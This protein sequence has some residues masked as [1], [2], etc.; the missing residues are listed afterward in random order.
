MP[1]SRAA[2]STRRPTLLKPLMP[3]FGGKNLVG[4]RDNLGLVITCS[5]SGAGGAGTNKTWFE[6]GSSLGSCYT[7]K[8]TGGK[9]V[10]IEWQYL[11]DEILR[12][13]HLTESR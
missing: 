6:Q 12:V 11:R 2:L 9:T 8:L 13:I 5:S 1:D 10:E 3:T 7:F 4:D